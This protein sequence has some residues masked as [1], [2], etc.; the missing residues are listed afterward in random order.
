MSSGPFSS[1]YAEAREKF[2]EAARAAGAMLSAHEHPERGPETVTDFGAR[3]MPLYSTTRK[4]DPDADARTRTNYPLL[5][6]FFGRETK[7][8]HFVAALA[9]VTTPVLILGGDEDPVLPPAYQ[10]AIEA[11]LV[12][13]PVRRI[14]YP[15][16]GHT[17]A[18]D[19][20]KALDADL[21]AWV[22]GG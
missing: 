12:N 19:A 18:R 10:D 17:L 21:R 2:L 7:A 6:D 9:D 14:S 20:P 16:V 22:L 8:F 3:C 15:G 4:T 13:A 11:A 1:S 5:F